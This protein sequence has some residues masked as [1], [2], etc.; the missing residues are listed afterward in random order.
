MNERAKKCLFDVL[1]SIQ[2]I[3]EFIGDM[4]F[5]VYENDLKTKS[6]VERQLAIVGEAIR[7]FE[8]ENSTIQ[9]ANAREIINFRN[10]LVHAYDSID[11]S[12]VWAIKTN[13][14][15]LL[16]EEITKLLNE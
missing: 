6:A 5:L 13:H 8:K 16:K 3:E 4:N 14:L 15:P 7:N 12:I 10:R 2:R 11:D 9:L 1:I